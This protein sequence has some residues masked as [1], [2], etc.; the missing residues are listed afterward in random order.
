MK[1]DP[2]DFSKAVKDLLS[3][4]ATVAPGQVEIWG[5]RVEVGGMVDF[6]GKWD[7]PSHEMPWRIWEYTNEIR[8]NNAGLD[9]GDLPLLER[10]RLFGPGGD[11]SLRRDDDYFLWHFI[12]TFAAPIK[13]AMPFWGPDL[14]TRDGS[15][16][17][18]GHFDSSQKRWWE[19]RVGWAELRYP[20]APRP[21]LW[22]HYTEFS[23]GGQVAFV[24]WKELMDHA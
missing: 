12:G 17:L 14:K 20:H 5:G 21:R 13:E 22:L 15:V 19:D 11:L 18:W 1:V 9:P 3:P 23:D 24:W 10:G 8:F 4:G 6:L 2:I 16:L 7:L